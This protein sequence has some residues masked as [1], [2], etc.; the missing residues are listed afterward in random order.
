VAIAQAADYDPGRLRQQLRLMLDALGGLGDVVRPGDRVAI[1]VNL[2]GGTQAEPAAGVPAVE[3]YVTHPQVVHALGELLRD[4]GA[5]ELLIAEAVYDQESYPSFGYEEVA[6][7]LDATLIDLNDPQP[8]SDFASMPVGEGWFIYDHFA[9]HRALAEVDAFVSVA[10]LK[11]HYECGVTL[12][13]KNLIGL[14]PVTQYRLDGTH[15][16]RSALHGQ[17]NEIKRRLPRVILDLNRARPIHL[18]VID[19]IKT[20]EGGEVPRGSFHP[21]EP[22][23]LV[24]GKNAVATDAVA[25]AVMSFVPT[26]ESP[27]APFLRGDNHLNLAHGLGLGTNHLEEI[28]VLGAA[29]DEVRFKFRPSTEM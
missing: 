7:A 18:A 11:C 9:I 6:K 13:M 28:Q 12:S 25:T 23:V 4:A 8:Y 22:G 21:V 19:G 15:W 5:R 20:A 27:A 10:K 29:I 1:K 2:T 24:A 3:S 26:V 14:V 16:W 17:A